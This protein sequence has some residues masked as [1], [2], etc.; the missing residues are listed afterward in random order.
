VVTA[1]NKCDGDKAGQGGG[2]DCQSPPA[3]NNEDPVLASIML[4]TWSTRCALEAKQDD[5]S[6]TLGGQIVSGTDPKA[7]ELPTVESAPHVDIAASYSPD[8]ASGSCLSDRS[9]D[10]MGYSVVIPW[11]NT[12]DVTQ[13]MGAVICLLAGLVGYRGVLKAVL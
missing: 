13:V 10:V 5:P 3:S 1:T 6:V 4:Q 9:V 8:F 2:L 12:C 11:S 7:S